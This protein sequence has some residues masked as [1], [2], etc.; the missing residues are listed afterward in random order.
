MS[1]KTLKALKITPQVLSEAL[2]QYIHSVYGI[3]V[4]VGDLDLKMVLP[5][6][7]LDQSR[8]N[9]NTLT[10]IADDPTVFVAL[11]QDTK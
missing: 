1:E 11:W 6:E 8:I 3:Q 2:C 7:L 4:K 5:D 10:S 9:V